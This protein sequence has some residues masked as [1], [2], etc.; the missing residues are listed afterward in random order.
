MIKRLGKDP[1]IDPTASVKNCTFGR[2]CEVMAH[3]RLLEVEMGD[4]SYCA[5]GADI[6]CTTIGK[7]SNIAA[8]TRINPGNHPMDRAAMHHFMYRSAQYWENAEDDQSFFD[9]RRQYRVEI[10]H[11]TWLG[12]GA[13]VLPGRRIATGAV[14]GAGAVVTKDVAPYELVA[15]NPARRLRM[16]FP[17]AICR[18]L[19]AL[20]WWDWDHARLRDALEDFRT[21]G[22]EA[23]LDQYDCAQGRS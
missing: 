11:D 14:V 20:A 23:F 2:Y 7:F 13:I 1:L 21:L 15:G 17:D 19:L 12:H 22:I 18:R 16:R 4:Y 5:H 6:F 10:G 8:A 9:W 3:A